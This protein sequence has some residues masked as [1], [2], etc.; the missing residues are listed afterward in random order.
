MNQNTNH[1]WFWLVLIAGGFV[2]L[3]LAATFVPEVLNRPVGQGPATWG[4][5]ASVVY[6]VFNVVVMAMAIFP[7]GHSAREE[8]R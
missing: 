8:N 2:A 1:K 3:A 7:F 6:L 5:V 4:L